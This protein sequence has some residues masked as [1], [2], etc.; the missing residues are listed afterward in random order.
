VFPRSISLGKRV[1]ERTKT[2]NCIRLVTV[3]AVVQF[4]PRCFV[5]S[6][7]WTVNFSGAVGRRPAGPVLSAPN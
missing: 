2:E 5:I 7:R 3:A 1:C 6:G 4:V